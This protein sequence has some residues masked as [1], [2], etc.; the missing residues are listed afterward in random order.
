M[1]A[2]KES[3]VEVKKDIKKKE[4]LKDIFNTK[5]RNCYSLHHF[6]QRIES[7]KLLKCLEEDRKYIQYYYNNNKPVE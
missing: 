4:G 7:C 3:I 2:K 1:E 6:K 5:K